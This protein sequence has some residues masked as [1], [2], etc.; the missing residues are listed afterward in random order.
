MKHMLAAAL[1]LFGFL[2]IAP[3]PG[4]AD[5]LLPQLLS[6]A[7]SNPVTNIAGVYM[8]SAFASCPSLTTGKTCTATFPAV[9]SGN[10]LVVSHV[11]CIVATVGS[12]IPFVV[13]L[14]GEQETFVANG[15]G[16]FFD[17]TAYYE[18]TFEVLSVSAAGH[19]PLVD[20][21]PLASS[22]NMTIECTIAGKLQK[23]T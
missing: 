16:V 12:A 7:P 17:G 8:A 22:A 3:L 21:T 2:T 14:I 5:Q 15:L 23:S 20:V 11:S 18:A 19:K 13:L 1:G 4:S 9:P 10:S 6:E